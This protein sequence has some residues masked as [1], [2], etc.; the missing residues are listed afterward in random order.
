MT[1]LIAAGFL[2]PACSSDVDFRYVLDTNPR[3]TLLSFRVGGIDS[4][5]RG[6]RMPAKSIR[7]FQ[8]GYSDGGCP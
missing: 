4:M 1:L 2:V 8:S 3:P 7:H 6:P 5:P